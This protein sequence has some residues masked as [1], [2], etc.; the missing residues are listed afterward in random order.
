MCGQ[1]EGGL[2]LLAAHPL[3]GGIGL[4]PVPDVLQVADQAFLRFLPQIGEEDPQKGQPV[5]LLPVVPGFADD[6]LPELLEDRER[7]GLAESL[8]DRSVLRLCLAARLPATSRVQVCGIIHS[9]L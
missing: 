6:V 5:I 1:A 9:V 8:M 2:H 7:G 3:Q 4:A